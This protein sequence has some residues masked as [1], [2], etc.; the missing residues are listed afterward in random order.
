MEEQKDLLTS[1]F[2]DNSGTTPLP[3]ATASLVLGILSLVLSLVFFCI[4]YIEFI[5]LGLGITGLI[6]SNK[7][8]R[9]YMAAPEFYS[10]ASFS[11]SNAGRICSIIGIVIASIILVFVIIVF[12]LLGTLSYNDWRN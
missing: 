8:R 6:L 7:D 12:V 3:N 5:P 10:R 11:S 2:N 4:F 9:L 1:V